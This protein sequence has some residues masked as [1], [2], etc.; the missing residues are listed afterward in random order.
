[1]NKEKAIKLVSIVI[2]LLITIVLI[3]F[4]LRFV[5]RGRA[6]DLTPADVKVE[7]VTD[8]S[9]RVKYETRSSLVP[10]VNYGQSATSLNFIVPASESKDLGND[11]TEY[12]HDVTLLSNPG[13][14]YYFELRIGEETFDNGGVPFMVQLAGGAGGGTPGL[15]PTSG[16]ESP[17]SAP[18]VTSSQVA[19]PTAQVLPL[20]E[21]DDC[22]E[23]KEKIG[24]GY[25]ARDYAECIKKKAQ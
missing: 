22:N 13:G 4:G 1:M 7:N 11:R 5:Q 21:V 17:T 23:V 12:N 15:S 14:T 9:F 10:V 24:S 19:A 25:T 3:W 18:E 8:T 6:V 2:G 20:S 16:A